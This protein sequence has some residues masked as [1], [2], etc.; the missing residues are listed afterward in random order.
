MFIPQA[1]KEHLF[2]FLAKIS[3]I[4]KYLHNT[5]LNNVCHKFS[6]IVL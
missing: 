6:T 4:V 5:V 2:Q 1:W 3:I